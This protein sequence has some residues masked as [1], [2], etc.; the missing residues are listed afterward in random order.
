MNGKYFVSEKPNLNLQGT[1]TTDLLGRNVENPGTQVHFGV[2]LD[3]RQ[4]KKDAWPA[5]TQSKMN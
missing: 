2:S 3:A 5:P 4:D 1:Q